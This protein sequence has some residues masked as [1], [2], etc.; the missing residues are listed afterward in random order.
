MNAIEIMRKILDGET[1]TVDGTTVRV[2]VV[3]GNRYVV[4]VMEGTTRG[5][6]AWSASTRPRPTVSGSRSSAARRPKR[7]R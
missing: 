5:S 4:E 7:W 6:A 1:A 2:G 3:L